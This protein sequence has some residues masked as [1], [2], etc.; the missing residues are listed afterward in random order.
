MKV[1]DQFQPTLTGVAKPH[2]Y[3]ARRVF[4]YVLIVLCF[5]AVVG[6]ALEQQIFEKD[7]LQ[8]EGAKRHLT[9]V[10]VPAHRG[11]ILDRRGESLAVS[12]P[13]S[14]IWVDPKR[15]L[16][17]PEKIAI[18]AQVLERDPVKLMAWMQKRKNRR[19]V[20]LSR[21]VSPD[22]DVKV[23]YLQDLLAIKKA[24]DVK[25]I[26]GRLFVD[27]EQEY[28][29]FYP[30]GEVFAHVVGF[31]DIDDKGQEGLE[32]TFDEW[33]EGHPGKKRILKDGHYRPLDVQSI[34]AARDGQDLVLSLDRRIQ[35]LADREL[36]LTIR[37][38]Q[39][40]SGTAV[41]LDVKTGEV[42]AM[43]NRPV[44]N[45]NANK[46]NR[47]G[48]LR[49]RAMTDQFEPGS[50]M[51][52]FTVAL[53]LE[54][55]LVTPETMIDTTPGTYRVGRKL[56]RDIKNY[57]NIDVSTIIKKSSNVGISKI[58]LE[59]P[60]QD[61]WVFLSHLGFAELTQTGFVGEV[62]GYLPLYTEWSKIGQATLSYGY[63][64]SVTALQLTRAYA[65]LAAQGI[66]YPV[67]LLK[68]E[69][70]PEGVRVMKSE[71]AAKLTKMMEAVVS[72]TGTAPKAAIAG[73]RVAG[74]TGTV[75]K[76]QAGGYAEHR[77]LAVFAGYAPA[78]DPRLAMVV[79][80]DEPSGKHYY[81]GSV[82]APLFSKVMA[83]ALRLLN[84]TPDDLPLESRPAVVK[85]E[86]KG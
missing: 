33:L 40:S 42:L 38:F 3:R 54:N 17:Y 66:K 25:P 30:S 75:K 62:T 65:V 32:L 19:H 18:V 47:Y 29:R 53:A 50:T 83:G 61:M 5:M 46:T 74:K 27:L 16:A 64:L 86:A 20:F 14:S 6:K 70:E 52:P 48:E 82:A 2:E 37:E 76:S 45:P 56:V 69:Q 55:E 79:M 68:L 81:G 31:T 84:V 39:A 36:E 71:T 57:G 44:Y 58:A 11:R 10:R 1:D 7:F 35:S 60:K 24:K 67:S 13:V 8:D 51:K 85:S 78:S 28:R 63:G 21:R 72:D 26:P 15:L 9:T 34:K 77:Y 41:V 43:V 59:L 80:I 22:V 73:Y 4:I 49:N 23:E 12:A